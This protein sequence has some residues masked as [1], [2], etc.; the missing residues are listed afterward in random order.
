MLSERL[1]SRAPPD[2]RP[3]TPSEDWELIMRFVTLF[4]VCSIALMAFA[5][6]IPKPV[7]DSSIVDPDAKFELLYTRTARLWGGLTE[8]PAVAPDG[9]IYVADIR[10][11]RD[12]GVIVRFD[13]K[14]GEP[15]IF[16]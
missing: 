11:G 2:L 3:P 8:G 14:T 6:D 1:V 10:E 7:G 13:S 16:T 9:S 15:A 12:K 4:A 5:A